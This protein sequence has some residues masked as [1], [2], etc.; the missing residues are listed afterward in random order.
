[1]TRQEFM[2]HLEKL[3]W[4]I[5]ESERAEALQYYKDYFDDAGTENEEKVLKE[6]GSSIQVAKKIKAGFSETASEY[7]EQGYQDT[8]FRDAMEM[9]VEE[10]KQNWQEKEGKQFT[11]GKRDKPAVGRGWKVLAIILLCLFLLPVII[12]LGIALLGVI[13]GIVASLAAVIFSIGI[14]GIAILFSGVI[15]IVVGIM[16]FFTLPAIGLAMAGTGC[17]LFALGLL[18]SWII[19]RGVIKCIPWIVRGIVKLFQLPFRKAGTS[20]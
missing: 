15:F 19:F 5:P 20:L 7:S 11:A 16:K 4:D 3:L 17:I 1:M 14:A 8:R 2:M 12:P 6:L 9:I 13:L 10:E 18:I